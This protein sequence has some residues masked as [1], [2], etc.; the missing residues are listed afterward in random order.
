MC[1]LYMCTHT[2]KSK[3]RSYLDD[4]ENHMVQWSVHFKG[5]ECIF[6]R[7]ELFL[8]EIKSEN[9]MDMENG[10]GSLSRNTFL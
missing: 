2:V 7:F 5:G 3:G 8:I 6:S 4:N 10:C 9:S 1:Y